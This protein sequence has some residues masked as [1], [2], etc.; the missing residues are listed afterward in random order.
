MSLG[1]AKDMNADLKLSE[2]DGTPTAN[3]AQVLA[4]TAAVE[5]GPYRAAPGLIEAAIKAA[6][7]EFLKE[8]GDAP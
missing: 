6:T 5:I 2:P 8:T 3:L 7:D 1:I 4:Q